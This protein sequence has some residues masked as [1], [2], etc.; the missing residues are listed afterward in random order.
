MDVI[1]G[2]PLVTRGYLHPPLRGWEAVAS[3][4]LRQSAS[5]EKAAVGVA[6]YFGEDGLDGLGF[7]EG[8]VGLP[9]P[10]RALPVESPDLLRIDPLGFGEGE[11][12]DPF[13]ILKM[14]AEVK[15]HDFRAVDIG[16]DVHLVADVRGWAAFLD[17]GSDGGQAPLELG[18]RQRHGGDYPGRQGGGSM[19]EW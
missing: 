9:L 17:E 15:D 11:F 14:G 7:G 3:M 6:I 16:A 19:R 1:H 4:W 10:A 2:F 8:F 18:G 13:R 12:E 5:T